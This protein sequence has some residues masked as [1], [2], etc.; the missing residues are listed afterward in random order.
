MGSMNVTMKWSGGLKF[1]GINVWGNKIVAD[2]ARSSGG[3]ESG[4]KP[5]EMLLYAVASCTG[6]DVVR[7]LEKQRQKLTSLEIEVIAHQQDDYP[8]PFHTVEVIY[9]ARGENLDEK[10]LAMAIELSESKYCVISQTIARPA[11]V[12]TSYEILGV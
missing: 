1:E 7:I 6:V 3:E 9:R 8:K 10:K 2:V 5:T 11:E 12:K 4:I